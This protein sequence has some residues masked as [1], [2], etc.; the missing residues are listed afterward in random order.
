LGTLLL[1]W[2]AIC[3]LF[4]KWV[5]LPGLDNCFFRIAVYFSHLKFTS[6]WMPEASHVY[7]KNIRRQTT[8]PEESNI[9]VSRPKSM[10]GMGQSPRNRKMVNGR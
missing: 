8:I 6:D 4:S 7:R 10:W 1:P 2:I 9:Y 3:G 5:K